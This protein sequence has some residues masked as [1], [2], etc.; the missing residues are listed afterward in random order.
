MQRA[1][2][3]AAKGAG[4]T[5]PNP[6]VG[7]VIVK[8][9][10]A[11]GEGYHTRCGELH[12][13]REAL[14]DCR[15]R[16]N[17]PKG[18]TLYV[19]LEPCC[20]TGKQ[21]PCTDAIIEAGIARVVMGSSDPN[22]LVAGK[23]IVQLR[24]AGIKVDEGCMTAECDELNRAWLYFI[25]TG[26]P[27]ITMKYA[28]T[29]DGKIA[30]CTGD[31]KWITG[32]QAREHAH[33][34]RARAAGIVVGIGTVLADDPM[35][36]ARPAGIEN[37]HQPARIVIDTQLR[38]PF[39]SQ[40]ALTAFD[41]PT[42]LICEPDAPASRREEL[43]DMGCKI[44]SMPAQDGKIDLR[45]LFKELGRRGMDSLIVEGG[46]TLNGSLLA[47]GMVN[48]VQT[49]IAPKIIGG[50]NAPSPVEGAGIPM[51]DYALPI[52]NPRVSQLGE[53]FLIEGCTFYDDYEG[54]A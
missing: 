28:M 33:R 19:T 52:K 26:L 24:A 37:P 34:E 20:H 12:A 8:D 47:T 35:L 14:A 10:L 4:W 49:Y 21:P 53:D 51:M 15:Q 27:F 40:L 7:A 13:E 38:T 11:I 43:H 16:G 54:E 32:E 17:D 2:E 30:S 3:L 48:R 44:V 31:S 50:K 29:L 25:Q 22:P 1:L 23:G 36:T 6:Q 45:E 39:E 41:Y 46:A 5:A 18:A 9:G 42:Y